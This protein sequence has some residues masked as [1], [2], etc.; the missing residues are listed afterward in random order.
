ML[1]K[2]I[3]KFGRDKLFHFGICFVISLIVG[4]VMIPITNLFGVIFSSLVS[5]SGAALA[6]EY[7][8]KCSPTNKWDW[9]DVIADYLGIGLALIILIV[10]KI[11]YENFI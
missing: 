5:G 6:K 1:K 11:C 7:G 8:D 2:L 10:L 9:K 3:K 4:L